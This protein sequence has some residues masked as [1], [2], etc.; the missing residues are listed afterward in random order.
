MLICS[1]ANDPYNLAKINFFKYYKNKK[2][3]KK[4]TEIFN[5]IM[6]YKKHN[7]V[8]FSDFFNMLNPKNIDTGDFYELNDFITFIS[9]TYN[10]DVNIDMNGYCS[11][12]IFTKI[13]IYSDNQFDSYDI[14]IYKN[15]FLEAINILF[16]SQK[17]MIEFIKEASNKKNGLAK[18]IDYFLLNHLTNYR[19]RETLKH[20]KKQMF[21]T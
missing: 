21:I 12:D 4:D 20:V 10:I 19:D 17:E 18:F 2:T 1:I 15:I 16:E 8:D 14:S 3:L 9:D 11:Y 6:R 13:I 5:K 7:I